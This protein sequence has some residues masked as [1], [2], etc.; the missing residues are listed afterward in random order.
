MPGRQEAATFP[1]QK[2][3]RAEARRRV[4]S[5][6]PAEAGDGYEL[7]RASVRWQR[8]HMSA[9]TALPS[10]WMV[11]CWRF[12]LKRRCARTLFIP[13]DCA[14]NPSIETF[15]QTAQERAI[16]PLE[17]VQETVVPSGTD[18]G[19]MIAHRSHRSGRRLW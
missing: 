5:T 8:V 3:R 9:F 13:D 11:V 16:G 19:G 2:R 7:A 15:P 4:S 12:G 6:E 18:R 17:Y 10:S 14:L 1:K